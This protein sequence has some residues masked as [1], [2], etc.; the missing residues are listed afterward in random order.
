MIVIV[1]AVVTL[2]GTVVVVVLDAASAAVVDV[3]GVFLCSAALD[4]N[5]SAHMSRHHKRL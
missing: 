1:V 3:P 2:A 5:F 4:N